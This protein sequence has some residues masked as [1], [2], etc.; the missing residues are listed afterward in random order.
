MDLLSAVMRN[1]EK[2]A[3]KGPDFP[4]KQRRKTPSISIDHDK[5]Q[6]GGPALRRC[7]DPCSG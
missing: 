2:T 3:E 7:H 5:E 6:A 1:S 4:L